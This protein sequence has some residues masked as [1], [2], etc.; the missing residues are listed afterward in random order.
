MAAPSAFTWLRRGLT[1]TVTPKGRLRQN[2][3]RLEVCHGDGRWLWVM[4]DIYISDVMQSAAI[5]L[6]LTLIWF[7]ITWLIK[8][9]VIWFISGNSVHDLWL[10]LMYYG[11]SSYIIIGPIIDLT[12]DHSS[13]TMIKLCI[14]QACF[15]MVSWLFM[16]V[17]WWWLMA[18]YWQL[19][20]S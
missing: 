6:W 1:E 9:P 7:I 2:L 18:S 16:I 17:C 10:C 11:W 4:T 14:D 19:L 13:L 12:V 3:H 20:A 8:M 15:L 5:S